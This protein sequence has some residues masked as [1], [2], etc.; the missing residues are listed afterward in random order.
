MS[1]HTVRERT[2][3]PI[4]PALIQRHAS[5]AAFYWQQHDQSAHSP[6][7]G[8][9]QLQEFDRLLDAHLDGL[10]VAGPAGWDTALAELT[11]WRSAPELFVCAT[12][13]LESEASGPRLQEIWA[14]LQT[15]PE[16]MLRGLIAA[17][18]WAPA[19][20]A[21]GWCVYW[22]KPEAPPALA[23]AAWRARALHRHPLEAEFSAAIPQALVSPHTEVRAACCRVAAW[24]QP[25]ALWPLLQD[26]QR[27]VRAEAAIALL[28]APA[29]AP[30]RLGKTNPVLSK[31][32]HEHAA[33]VLWQASESLGHELGGLSGWYQSRAQHRLARWVN[34]L[35]LIAPLG[36]PAMAQ[37]L[38]LLPPRLGL[39]LA[40]H[41]GDGHCLP[42]VL[43][44]MHKPEVS[45]LA[46]WVWSSFTGVSLHAQGLALPPRGADQ[47]PRPTDVQ[48]P[49]LP[50]PD[51][52]RIAALGQSLPPNVASLYG[53]PLDEDSLR[54]TLWYAPQALRWI[55]AQRLARL[56][57]APLNTRWHARQQQD[58]LASL[59][60]APVAVA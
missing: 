52:A 59:T 28:S 35:G 44:Q 21:M 50:E 13:A 37:L 16:R 1:L 36:H 23:V 7:V 5:D 43:E 57:Q 18:A 22:L 11:R 40:L 33:G 8:L 2:H 30:E 48:D 31:Q 9:P 46:A 3:S 42:W 15:Q 58:L 45:R 56:G 34:H 32:Q 27:Q 29:R 10:R 47:A 38:R 20:R 41:H 39:W 51:V 14:V 6:L 55:A 54:S 25:T 19:D 12:L 60:P 49:G 53:Q 17:L 4:I 26:P 24:A